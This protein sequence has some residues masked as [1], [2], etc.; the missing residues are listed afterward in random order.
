MGHF[1]AVS[2]FQTNAPDFVQR[3][4]VEYCRLHAVVC[5][6][7]VP[8][9]ASDE[10][11]DACMY[12]PENGWTRVMWPAFFNIYDFELCRALA[13]KLGLLASTVHVYDDDYWEHLFVRGSEEIHKFWSWPTYFAD[14]PTEAEALRAEWRGDPE[15]LAALLAIP[16]ER[17]AGYMVHLPLEAEPAPATNRS[18]LQ[19]LFGGRSTVP[20]ATASRKA[21]T[22]DQFAIDDFWVFT[23]FWRQLGIIYPDPVDEGVHSILRFDDITKLPTE[24]GED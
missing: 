17:I 22:T 4:I 14:D 3:G 10:R 7:R 1:L 6:P 5:E 12:T 24:P 23:D 19:R 18:W 20:P 11:R 21:Y 16:R 2:A 15:A 13:S 9:P 8:E